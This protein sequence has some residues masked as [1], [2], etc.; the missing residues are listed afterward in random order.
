MVPE[1]WNSR[2]LGSFCLQFKSLN[3]DGVDLTPLS[4]TKSDGVIPQSAKFN[5]RIA[6]ADTTKYKI[7]EKGDFVYDPMSLYYGA[8][9]WQRCVER[10]IASP[11]Y[12]TFRL[13]STVLPEYFWYLVKSTRAQRE[14]ISRT[15]GGNFHGKRKKTDWIAKGC[16]ETGGGLPV[17]SPRQYDAAAVR[18]S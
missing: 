10:G 11:A 17:R 14:F 3:S 2:R 5:K 13:D 18:G 15:A 7:L 16:S 9:G 4:V 6:I 12:I 1:G 8:I